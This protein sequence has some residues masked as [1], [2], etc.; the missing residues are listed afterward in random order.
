MMAD[1]IKTFTDVQKTD[2]SS[3]ITIYILH[4]AINHTVKASL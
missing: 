2:T 4:S 1:G 3:L